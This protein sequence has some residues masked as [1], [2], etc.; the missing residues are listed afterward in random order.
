MPHLP[1]AQY[2]TAKITLTEKFGLTGLPLVAASA[3][4]CGL[5]ATVVG[6]PV[7]VLKA[8][9]MAARGGAGSIGVLNTIQEI[10]RA[11]GVRGFYRGFAP[12]FMRICS[13][14]TV[15]FIVL[16]SMRSVTLGRSV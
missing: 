8:R 14:N 6:S 10:A 7:D 12:N 11:E 9:L 4:V 2:D 3:S 5:A 1:A 16:E 15:F 13:W